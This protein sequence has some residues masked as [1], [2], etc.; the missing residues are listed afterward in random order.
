MK[1]NIV[2]ARTGLLWVKLGIK[3]FVKQPLALASLCYMYLALTI[4]LSLIPVVGVLALALVPAAT[5]GLM[6][7]T[8]QAEMGKFPMPT[9]LAAAFRTGRQRLRAMLVLGL[10]YTAAMALAG[11]LLPLIVDM[12]PPPGP[13]EDAGAITPQH[14]KASMMGSLLALP[15]QV[16]FWHAPALVHWHGVSPVKSIFFSIVAIVRNFKAMLLFSLGWFGV[17]MA[18]SILI[19][20]VASVFGGRQLVT[21]LAVPVGLLAIAMFTT[22]IYFTFRDSFVADAATDTD[23]N[24]VPPPGET[25]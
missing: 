13:G 14:M 22:S 3:T 7:A 23:N 8:Q 15:I 12:P 9:V 21:L 25:P 17:L 1:L 2:P 6:V 11:L 24:T 19:S 18:T 16:A 4:V 5:L 10:I 20:V